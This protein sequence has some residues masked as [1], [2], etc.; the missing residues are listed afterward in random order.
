MV[1]HAVAQC[2]AVV[3]VVEFD[4]I[5]GI[6]LFLA[7]SASKCAENLQ[8]EV[9]KLSKSVFISVFVISWTELRGVCTKW[10]NSCQFPALCLQLVSYEAGVG[11]FCPVHERNWP[12]KAVLVGLLAPITAELWLVWRVWTVLS[13]CS[14][15]KG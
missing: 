6:S 9:F 3:G 4:V 15:K 12:R 10:G 13:G 7:V 14:H 8:N 2:G 11:L 5:L 1:W